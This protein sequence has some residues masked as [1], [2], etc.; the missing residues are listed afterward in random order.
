[1]KMR[2]IKIN[3]MGQNFSYRWPSGDT[4]TYDFF[5]EYIA[6]AEDGEHK[7]KV[8]FG[9]RDCYGENRVRVIILIDEHV[10][11]EFF[12]ADDFEKS[13]EILSEIKLPGNKGERICR[14]PDEPI[15][16]RY[17]M[18]NVVGLPVR[19]QKSGVHN[20]WAVAANIADHKTL[21]ALAALRR[22]E[23]RR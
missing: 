7:V 14:Y 10:E 8:M 9:K 22:L 19:V 2:V 4:E 12:G 20:A 11:A 17:A 13:G 1:M 21:I 5:V 23:R 6:A 18:F 3:N 16:E 15:P